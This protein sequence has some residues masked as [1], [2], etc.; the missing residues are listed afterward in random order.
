MPSIISDPQAYDIMLRLL[1]FSCW[2]L[3]YINTV[4]TTLSDQLPSVSFMSICCDVAWEFVYAFVYP[5]ASS[6]WAGGIRI[7]FAMHC[8]MLFIVAKYA[9][10]DWDH[11]PLM[12]RFARLAYVAITIGFMAGHLA[13]ASEIGPALGFFWSGALCQ[14]TAS[15]GSLCLLVCR[16]STR[17]ASIKTCPLC[18]FYIAITLTL[19]AIYPVF[20]FYFRAIEHPK[21]DSERK[22]E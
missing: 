11:V 20:F 6:H 1:Q 22:V 2:S 8:V 15:L 13:L 9:P 3:S 21:K 7:W 18:W 12:K 16:G 14:I 4:R 5:I 10:N 19:D 17:G